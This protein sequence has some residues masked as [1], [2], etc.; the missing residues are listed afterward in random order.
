MSFTPL[1]ILYVSRE[2]VPGDHGGAVHT[3]QVASLLAR[4]GH[5]V[6]LLSHRPPGAPRDEER[7]GVTI[8]RARMSLRRRSIPLLALPSLWRWRR[9]RFD[10]VMERFDSF[11]G[12]AAIHAWLTGTPLLL[13]VNYPHLEEMVWKWQTRRSVLALTPLAR[14]LG[15]WNRW[16]YSR[17][18]AL[19]APRLSIVPEAH[20]HKVELVHWGAN[21]EQLSP[22]E[23][24]QAAAALRARLRLDGRRV[25]VAHGSFQP[26]HGL[27]VFP[28]IVAR[29]TAQQEDATFLFL[30]RGPGLEEIERRVRAQ[31]LEG[32]CRFAGPVEH[33]EIPRYLGLAELALA[34]FDTHAYPPLERFGFFWSPA[35]LFE[36]MACGVPV[37]TTDQDYLRQVVEAEG[38]GVCLPEND[39]AAIAAGI[40]RLLA[41][42]EGRARLGQAGRKAVTERYSWQA[43]VEQL[44]R[45]LERLAA[46]RRQALQP[47]VP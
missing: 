22:P 4:R 15:A 10:V 24:T 14:L 19:I 33:A 18:A 23:S 42:P 38:A 26:W 35:K 43:H 47:E 3:W 39:A 36:Y 6:T 12:V 40:L 32:F 8:R 44:A 45:I 21:V 27:A 13:E 11:G 37:V 29:V 46:E 7:D 5:Q 1:K 28:G 34:P 31:G 25:I 30:G 16:Q 17:A 2:D 41:D 20:R 9:Q